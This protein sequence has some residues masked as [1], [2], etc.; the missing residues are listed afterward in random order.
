MKQW[1]KSL[2]LMPGTGASFVFLNRTK[3]AKLIKLSLEEMMNE[4]LKP[5]YAWTDES[6]KEHEIYEKDLTDRTR[7]YAERAVYFNK[8]ISALK[9]LNMADTVEVSRFV[10]ATEEAFKLLMDD[11]TA[12]LR[13]MYSSK[14]KIVEPSKGVKK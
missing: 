13:Q 11:A 14:P 12:N 9:S 5:I 10:V 8:Q 6:G 7:P 4:K 1:E 2:T 3:L